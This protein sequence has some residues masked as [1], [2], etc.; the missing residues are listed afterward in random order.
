VRAQMD[1]LDAS[2]AGLDQQRLQ[3]MSTRYESMHCQ[4]QA[5]H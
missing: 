5:P 1:R 2:M 4:D 3:A